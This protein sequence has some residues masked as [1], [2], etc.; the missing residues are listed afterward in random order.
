[1]KKGISLILICAHLTAVFHF[2]VPYLSYYANFTYFATEA[3]INRDNPEVEC[4]GTCKLDEMVHQEH[5]R[6]RDSNAAHHVDRAPKI[7]FFFQHSYRFLHLINNHA[8]QTFLIE[9]EKI[10]SLWQSEPVSPPPQI[11]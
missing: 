9:T 11:A 6:D 8:G 7:H 5:Q 10:D 2:T 1:M 3:C 4:N